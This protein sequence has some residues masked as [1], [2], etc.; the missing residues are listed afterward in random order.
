MASTNICFSWF[1]KL[2]V[3]DQDGSRV[4][5]GEGSLP[6]VHMTVCLL[7][8]HAAEGNLL[9]VSLMRALMSFMRAP[10]SS[11]K[12]LSKFP[13]A[14]CHYTENMVFDIGIDRKGATHDLALQGKRTD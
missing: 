11:P 5:L 1:W 12:Y 4:V 2:E 9:L 8:V 3:Q 10:S 6:E 13:K 14:K 7:C